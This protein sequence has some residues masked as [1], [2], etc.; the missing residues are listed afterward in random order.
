M[1]IMYCAI[2]DEERAVHICVWVVF[3]S[4]K[5]NYTQFA[6]VTKA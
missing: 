4:L 5:I 2:R 6:T 1:N 3:A